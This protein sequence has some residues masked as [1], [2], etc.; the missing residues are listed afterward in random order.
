MSIPTTQKSLLLRKESAPYVVEETPVPTPGP[1]D[2]LV[3][4]FACALNP[5]DHAIVDPP[6]SKILIQE[7]PHIPGSDGA[8]V[9][10]ALG[11]DVTNLK[12]GDKVVFQG[13][14]GGVGATCQQYAIVPAELT[15][16][17][18]DTLTFEQ[19][20]TL[21]LALTTDVMSLY[22]QSPAPQNLSLRLKP[23]WEAEGQTA[24]AGTPALIIGA[25]ASLGQ[26][27][28]QLARLAGHNPI[29]ATASPHNAE[30]IKS[31][32]AT[33]V[34]DR[35]RSNE[36]I[37]S[38]LPVLIGGKHLEYA[39]VAVASA[40]AL[41]LGR[42]ALAPGGALATISPQAQMLPEDVV[43]IGDGKRL[44][45][46]FGSAR[47]PYT[48]ETGVAMFKALSGWLEKGLLKPNPVE[49]LPNGLAGINEGLAR[50]KANKV[51]GTKLVARPQETA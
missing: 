22:N 31:L 25:A 4:I 13:S 21:P 41:R 3:Q 33:H 12:E 43:N 44:S 30:L 40:D 7:W 39:F 45:F 26:V 42:D 8:G 46:V 51:S 37:L 38:E 18:P 19:A 35:S 16:I 10:V 36:S 1:K 28:V 17:I 49:V 11:A 50:M 14:G 6:Y 15:A 20:A 48:V 27:A 5:V 47:L 9:V 23:V 32:G 24:Y 2:V 34:L 29:I